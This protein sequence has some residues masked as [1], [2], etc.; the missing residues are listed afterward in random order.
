MS[1]QSTVLYPDPIKS[2]DS[3]T[4]TGSYQAVGTPLVNASRIFKIVNNSTK[5]ITVSFDGTSDHDFIP[6]KSFVL[7]D[8]TSN[9]SSDTPLTAFP[10][11]TQVY[12]KAA[13]GGGLVYVISFFGKS[14]NQWPYL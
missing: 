10:K 4:F 9:K 3:A 13:A 1:Y 6:T 5:D 2:I 11:G 8:F 14:N 12:V 7:Y